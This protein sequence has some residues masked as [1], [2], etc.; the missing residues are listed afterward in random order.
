M[1]IT[2]K[3]IWKNER[4]PE[5]TL[6]GRV[7]VDLAFEDGTVVTVNGVAVNSKDGK[8]FIGMP[9]TKGTKVDPKTNKIPYYD[10][11]KL[12]KEAYYRLQDAILAEFGNAQVGAAAPK[13]TANTSTRTRQAAPATTTR[14][15]VQVGTDPEEDPPF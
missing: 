11:V 7:D 1:E 14:Q 4:N 10:I 6:K 13:S 12:S 3:R 2:I 15:T 9:Q 5:W 8:N